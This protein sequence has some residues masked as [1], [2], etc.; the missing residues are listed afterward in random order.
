MKSV[1]VWDAPLRLVHW[2]IVVCV[3]L[4]WWTAE[5]GQMDYHRYSGY[6]VLGL[7]VFRLYWGIVGGDTARFSN[8]VK[9]PRAILEYVR[10]LPQRAASAHYSIPGHNP[11][12][13]VSVIVLLALLLTQVGLG[14]FAGDIDGLESGPLSAFVSFD[15][16]R[17]CAELHA[18][19]FNVLLAFICLHIVAVFFYL[20]FKR[21]NLI[22]TMI[23]GRRSF[24]ADSSPH[25]R[26][27]SWTRL[28]IGIAGAI[29]IAWAIAQGLQ[30]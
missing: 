14:L 25:V 21:D 30:F 6:T 3:G 16:T 8:F 11:L 22:A 13:A 29:F 9:G 18:K 24:P 1:R 20:V 23:H 2:S 27:A 28:L 4:S 5:I 19:V 26:F 12:G 7:L 17:V 15:T 10:R